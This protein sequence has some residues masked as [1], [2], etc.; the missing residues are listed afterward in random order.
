ME[1]IFLPTFGCCNAGEPTIA[2][3]LLQP[4][5]RFMVFRILSYVSLLVAKDS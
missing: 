1:Q 5:K 3:L 2:G 4:L